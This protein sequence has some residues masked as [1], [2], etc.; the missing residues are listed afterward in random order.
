MTMK[1]V[2]REINTEYENELDN[3]KESV[4]YDVIDMSGSR[5][6]WKDVLALYILSKLI[7]MKIILKK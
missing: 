6:F 3:I 5:A 4:E 1:D 2:D 7:L